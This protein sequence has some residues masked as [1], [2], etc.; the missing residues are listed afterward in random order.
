[1]QASDG[2]YRYVRWLQ[3]AAL[4]HSDHVGLTWETCRQ[5]GCAFVVRRQ[6]IDYLREAV[7]GQ[8]LEVSTWVEQ[9][10]PMSALRHTEI[11]NEAGEAVLTAQTLWVFMSLDT[12]RPKRIPHEVKARFEMQSGASIPTRSDS[13]RKG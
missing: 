6:T 13:D 8:R 7:L 2:A 3:D 4:R 10:T 9:N 11:R 12:R 1:M 5:M